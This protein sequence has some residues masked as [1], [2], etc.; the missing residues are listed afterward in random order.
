MANITPELNVCLKSQDAPLVL[1]KEYNVEK[2][3]SFLQEAYNI[4]SL[5]SHRIPR[6]IHTNPTPRTL[7]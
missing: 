5:L 2:I 6:F 4:V 3:N 7:A 1:K